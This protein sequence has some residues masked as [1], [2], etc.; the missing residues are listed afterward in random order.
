MAITSEIIGKLG[1]ADVETVE[2]AGRDTNGSDNTLHTD[3]KSVV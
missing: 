3:R 2:I 1:G